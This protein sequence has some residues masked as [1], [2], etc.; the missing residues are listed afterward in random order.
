MSGMFDKSTIDFDSPVAVFPLPQC[1]LLPHASVPLHIFEPRYRKMISD[2]LQG[3]RLVAMASF[4]G[5]DWQTD[6]EG[7]PPIRPVVCLAVIVQHQPLP[8]G[9]SNILLRGVCR[10]RVVRE[11]PHVPYRVA[12]LE[13][14]ESSADLEFDLSARRRS[15][16]GLI[17]DPTLRRL[18][19]VHS[20]HER[21]RDSTPTEA[22]IDLS[23]M[24]LVEDSEQ[25]YAMLAETDAL[26]RGA[27]L[28]A[29]LKSLRKII[30]AASRISSLSGT[31][32]VSLN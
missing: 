13:P 25:R 2:A 12:I 17:A 24:C 29:Q 21:L 18:A 23:I 4:A 3:D 5:S 1:V 32:E 11:M 8:D 15:I 10:A 22:L 28:E 27:W 6:Y 7:T 19:S 20:L 16:M 31:L 9:R 14:A 30:L 26:T